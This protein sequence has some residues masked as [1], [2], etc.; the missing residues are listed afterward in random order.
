MKIYKE[1][2]KAAL[3]I[4]CSSA[5]GSTVTEFAIAPD[6]RGRQDIW[7]TVTGVV[8][9][10]SKNDV[11]IV[12][13]LMSRKRVATL[14]VTEEMALAPNLNAKSI[15]LMK[16]QAADIASLKQFFTD[17]G[18][19]SASMDLASYLKE[20]PLRKQ[21]FP[22][23]KVQ[24]VFVGSP[25]VKYPDAYSMVNRY[26]TDAFLLT[27]D[28]PFSTLGKSS[29]LHD[30]TI[31]VVHSA[32]ASEFSAKDKNLHHAKVNRFYGIFVGRM[33][34]NLATFSG[35]LDHLKNV[36][37]HVFPKVGYGPLVPGDG[38]LRV[39]EVT[40]PR[41]DLEEQKRQ[42]SLWQ[43]PVTKK[44]LAAGTTKGLIDVGIT[45]DRNVDLDIYVRAD[46]DREL[47]YGDP[48]S[49]RYGGRLIKDITSL[50]ASRGFETVTFAKEVP[51]KNLRVHVNHYA[52]RT[53][54]PINVD[55][56]I[57]VNGEVFF[58]RLQLPAGEGTQGG[59]ARQRHPAWI[60]INV[61]VLLGM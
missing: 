47:F 30:I 7:P 29:A 37:S 18:Q 25:L 15:W 28:S 34:G 52:G 55:F 49:E 6:A 38:K 44:P 26:P 5:T 59:G 22:K 9:N 57:R 39:V 24:S 8:L 20:L 32:D 45:W 27:A 51:L 14:R 12:Y 1:I 56:R 10:G 31:H 50:P 13:D 2:C 40:D 17:K 33:G 23:D 61:P 36:G 4:A 48:G 16:H 54:E 43:A 42:A 58:N 11:V 46:G 53:T 41:I 60:E 3:A 21:E 19:D 35:S